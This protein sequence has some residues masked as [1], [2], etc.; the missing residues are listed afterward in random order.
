MNTT[1]YN[2]ELAETAENQLSVRSAVSALTVFNVEV[3][4]R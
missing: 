4:T 1:T 3:F 2:A